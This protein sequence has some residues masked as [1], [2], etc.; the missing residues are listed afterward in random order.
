MERRLILA[1]G[2]FLTIFCLAA[3]STATSIFAQAKKVGDSAPADA[4]IKE[5]EI[6]AKKYEF[7]P[8]SIEIP[9]NTLVKI[10][11]T[12]LDHEHGFELRAYRG[13]CVKFKPGEPAI[14]EFYSE[15]SGEFEFSCCKYCGLGHGKMKGTLIVR[16]P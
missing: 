4:P 10:H 5:I 1:F 11:L 3:G 12:V 7:S 14:V 6:Q 2:L 9:S 16:Q 8:S 13:S 15:K